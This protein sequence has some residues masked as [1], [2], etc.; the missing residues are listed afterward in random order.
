VPIELMDSAFSEIRR[1][2]KPGGVA[3]ISEPV[4]AGNFNEVL[5]LFHDERT[6]REAAFAAEQRAV[7]SG[8]LALAAQTFFLH[9]AHFADFGQFE[10][11]VI[12]VTHTEHKLSAQTFEKVR[13]RFNEH[14]TQDGVTLYTQ[15]RVDLLQKAAA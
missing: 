11:Q 10:E 1:V 3:Y 13:A 2:L 6:V 15:I 5:K 9:P 4:Y 12:K 7:A 8:Q 14:M